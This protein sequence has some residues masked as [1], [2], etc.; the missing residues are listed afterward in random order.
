MSR[1]T[2]A[3]SGHERCCLAQ[4]T[5]PNTRKRG[6]SLGHCTARCQTSGR[7]V[8]SRMSN[9][10]LSDLQVEPQVV[11]PL[12]RGFLDGAS[13]TRVLT[14][15]RSARTYG[16]SFIARERECVLEVLAL[17]VGFLLPRL[18]ESLNRRPQV[19][20]GL[21]IPQLFVVEMASLSSVGPLDFALSSVRQTLKN[22]VQN[23]PE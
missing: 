8:R 6:V 23:H 13:Q 14:E 4:R 16:S 3:G 1:Q 20:F 19:T 9:I 7:V 18:A 5:A 10:R 15:L 12:R 22:G 17:T 2:D 11:D 21:K